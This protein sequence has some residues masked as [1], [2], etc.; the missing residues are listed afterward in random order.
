M[1]TN[2][3]ILHAFLTALEAFATARPIPVAWPGREFTPPASGLWLEC[4]YQPNSPIDLGVGF[5]SSA[6]PRGLFTMVGMTR[7]SPTAAFD[8]Q[9]LAIELAALFP[10][11]HALAGGVHVVRNPYSSPYQFQPD[12]VGLTVS[13][14]YSG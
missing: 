9:E 2:R 3:D 5:N 6:V 7:P 11:G 13:I 10:K 14:E 12:R 8:L 4:Y 1:T